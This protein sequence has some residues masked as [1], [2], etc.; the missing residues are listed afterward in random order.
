MTKA[1]AEVIAQARE[2]GG[3]K[4]YALFSGGKD[5]VTVA[6]KLHSEGLLEACIFVDTSICLKETKDFVRS[7]CKE[8]AWKLIE[9]DR[10]GKCKTYEEF[11]MKYGF[12]SNAWHNVAMRELKWKPLYY[13]V[14]QH[15]DEGV[16]LCSGVRSKESKRRMANTEPYARDKSCKHMRWC[17]P[18]Y[19]WS[20]AEVWEY[21]HENK[22]KR[23]PVYSTLGLSGDCLC[24]AFSSHGEAEL[25][26]MFHPEMAERIRKL[27]RKCPK[28]RN[29][30]GNQSSLEGAS[31]QQRLSFEC[32]DCVNSCASLKHLARTLTEANDAEQ[33]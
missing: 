3:K 17:A 28:E 18:I 30:W 24:G 33:R 31:Q 29:T 10:M 26:S 27:E 32:A 5:S 13:W 23:S 15:K 8:Q 4:F 22:L 9:L 14:M 11:V 19:D 1:F 7:Y 20:D 16:V 2:D 21:I 12:P 25:I 6:H